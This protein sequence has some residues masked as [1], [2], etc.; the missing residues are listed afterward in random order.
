M[1]VYKLKHIDNNR[2]FY[3]LYNDSIYEINTEIWY[4]ITYA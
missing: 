4:N 1:T 2:L 3:T